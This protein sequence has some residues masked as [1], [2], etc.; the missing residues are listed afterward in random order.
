MFVAGVFSFSG[1]VFRDG[2]LEPFGTACLNLSGG[3]FEPFG[4]AYLKKIEEI[5]L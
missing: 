5:S 4:A 3:L 1:Q 2:L